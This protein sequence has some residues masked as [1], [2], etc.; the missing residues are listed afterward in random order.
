ML[1]SRQSEV[2]KVKI[3]TK[4]ENFKIQDGSRP[5]RHLFDYFCHG[6]QLD[7]MWLR[8][9]ESTNEACYNEDIFW[10]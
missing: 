5:W 10:H 7:T 1:F 3:W 2:E 4:S 9:I 8:L 6:N